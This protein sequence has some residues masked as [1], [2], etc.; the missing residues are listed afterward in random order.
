MNEEYIIIH[1]GEGKKR[2]KKQ[3]VRNRSEIEGTE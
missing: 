1:S 3:M 2:I